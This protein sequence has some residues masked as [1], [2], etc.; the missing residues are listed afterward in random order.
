MN[1][2]DPC[3]ARRRWDLKT[4]RSHALQ[5]ELDGFPNQLFNLFTRVAHRDD[6]RQVRNIRPPGS[7]TF[8]VN[9]RVR[10]RFSSVDS[11]PA[12]QVLHWAGFKSCWRRFAL[13]RII[14][15]YS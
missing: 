2:H 13:Q 6:A 11:S 5:V 3:E 15:Y 12:L 7:S 4:F 9:Y 1:V 8:L 10:N 14:L